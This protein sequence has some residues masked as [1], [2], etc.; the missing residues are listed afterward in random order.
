MIA[1]SLTTQTNFDRPPQWHT[2][3]WDDYL[4]VRDQL[5]HKAIRLFFHQGYLLV[6]TSPEGFNHARFNNLM[7]L[8][9]FVWFSQK[10]QQAFD[11]LNGCQME[12]EGQQAASPD[13]VL[14]IGTG[15]PQW[16]TGQSRYINLNDMRIPDLVGEVGDTTIATDL[17]EK[18]QLYAALQI[19]EYWVVD[20]KGA[21][22]LAFCLD[23]N[24]KYHQSEISEALSGLPIALVSQ[25][26]EQLN[27]GLPN[28]R[29]ALWFAQQIATLEA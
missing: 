9:F 14:Y 5:E 8:V 1:S 25:T 26:L 11:L 7:T 24:G 29:A 16:Q 21:R 28:G 6:D 12:K 18:K 27:Q 2:A 10:S 17:D 15:F 20:V 13:L 23:E 3:N 19:P 22:V 4:Q